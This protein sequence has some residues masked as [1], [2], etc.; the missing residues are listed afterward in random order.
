MN[1]SRVLPTELINE[2]Q[3]YI[4]G[5]YIYI[6]KK[7]RD[8]WGI[9]TGIREELDKRN[10]QIVGSYRDGIGIA[11]LAEGYRLS[12]ERIRSIVYGSGCTSKTEKGG[13]QAVPDFD[14][15]AAKD[16]FAN[17]AAKHRFTIR[18]VDAMYL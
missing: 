8:G 2:I 4:E 17:C 14:K 5:A 12:E 15:Q 13:E 11:E 10:E 9:A 16:V 1:A 7:R 6:P 3:A 18:C